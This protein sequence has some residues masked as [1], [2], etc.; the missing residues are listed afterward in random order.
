MAEKRKLV[1]WGCIEP[2]FRAGLL[3]NSQICRQYDADHKNS[4]VYKTTVS[5]GAIRKQ[6]KIKGWKRNLSDKVQAQIKE[7]LVRGQVRTDEEDGLTDQEI[8]SIAS[9]LPTEVRKSQRVRTQKLSDLGDDLQAVLLKSISQDSKLKKIDKNS[10]TRLAANAKT[11]DTL[12]S[13]RAK[14]QKMENDA[15]GLDDTG[16]EN[17]SFEDFLQEIGG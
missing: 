17:K 7:N 16:S 2:L 9:V 15:F 13:A 1:D 3:S 11:Y 10:R 5:E 8:I 12:V 4:Q 6:A 14:L